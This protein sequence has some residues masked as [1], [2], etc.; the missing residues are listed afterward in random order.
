M[1]QFIITQIIICDICPLKSKSIVIFLFTFFFFQIKIS[2]FLLFTC[3]PLLLL[4]FPQLYCPESKTEEFLSKALQPP[5]TS[6]IQNGIN[7]LQLLNVLDEN[8]NLTNLGKT[9]ANFS[10]HPRLSVALIYSTFLRYFIS[11]IKIVLFTMFI[12]IF[13]QQS[14]I[15]AEVKK[16][17]VFSILSSKKEIGNL[18][19]L[20]TII[21][22]MLP[23][24]LH[25]SCI[26][27]KNS[28]FEPF[29]F[30]FFLILCAKSFVMIV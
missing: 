22:F 23:F 25:I 7:E 9:I 14:Y 26:W 24:F 1:I 17:H 20:Q 3:I 12:F 5:V 6:A 28:L 30:F 21:N 11:F 18:Y 4:F 19:I 2:K 15:V 29:F 8:E 13:S 16:S 10:T 27:N